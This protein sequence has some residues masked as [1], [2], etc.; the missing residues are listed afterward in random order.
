MSMPGE[1]DNVSHNFAP[2][3]VEKSTPKAQDIEGDYRDL[4]G[5][6]S[7]IRSCARVGYTPQNWLL[8][9]ELSL[10]LREVRFGE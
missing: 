5:K 1:D 10:F 9:S 4:I 6:S 2:Y 7:D 8:G 3:K